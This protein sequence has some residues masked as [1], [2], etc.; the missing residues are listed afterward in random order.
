MKN[1][2]TRDPGHAWLS[3]ATNVGFSLMFVISTM[4]SCAP[5]RNEQLSTGRLKYGHSDGWENTTILSVPPQSTLYICDKGSGATSSIKKAL[6][7]WATAG[8]MASLLKLAEGCGNK[9]ELTTTV[10]RCGQ[11]G[12]SGAAAI[13][14]QMGIPGKWEIS[15]CQQGMQNNYQITLHEVGHVFGQCDR[16]GSG[17]L[18]HPVRGEGC[19]DSGSGSD[20]KYNAP[21]AMQAGGP[22][23]PGRVTEDDQNGIKALLAR[24]DV[25]G[26]SAWRAALKNPSNLPQSS[27]SSNPNGVKPQN[28]TNNDSNYNNSTPSTNP[29]GNNG[30]SEC[31]S[32]V[33]ILGQVIP[34]LKQCDQN[35][36]CKLIESAVCRQ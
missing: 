21:S 16:Y 33:N 5:P 31:G 19:E 14:S 8:G 17:G 12:S 20:G 27:D 6:M 26:A 1:L 7:E 10:E 4:I 24:N 23:N 35:G 13:T 22:N 11:Y 34:A 2:D 18:M 3:C 9:F 36:L 28:Q 32:F 25:T 30:T 29:P 15:Y